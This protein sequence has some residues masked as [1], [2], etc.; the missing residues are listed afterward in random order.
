[1]LSSILDDV[2]GEGGRKSFAWV[3]GVDK[4]KGKG[5]FRSNEGDKYVVEG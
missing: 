1:M 2:K 4:C 5:V 3:R